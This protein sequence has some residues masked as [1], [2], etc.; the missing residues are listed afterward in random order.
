[1]ISFDNLSPEDLLILINALTISLS[2]DKTT[3][4]LNVLGNLL[5]SV[6]SLMLVIAAQQQLL[7]SL[8]EK[9]TQAKPNSENGADN[10]ADNK[11]KKV[12]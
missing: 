2:E 4:D 10:V 1:M 9:N 6:G 7:S 5:V 3:D 8:K 12:K 11:S